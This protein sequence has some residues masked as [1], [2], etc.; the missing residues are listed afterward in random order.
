MVGEPHP[1]EAIEAPEL[2]PLRSA[3]DHADHGANDAGAGETGGSPWGESAGSSP[4]PVLRELLGL[5]YKIAW[6]EQRA[7]WRRC[8][9]SHG[10]VRLQPH[11]EPW[12]AGRWR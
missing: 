4:A 7:P 11:E 6:C 1:E 8:T 5:A 10:C 3:A 12:R 9:A 2:R